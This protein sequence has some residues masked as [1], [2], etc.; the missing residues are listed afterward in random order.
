M[1]WSS[2]GVVEK[3]SVQYPVVPHAQDSGRT[4]FIEMG[5]LNTEH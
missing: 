5:G 3:W 1:E 2:G 4:R